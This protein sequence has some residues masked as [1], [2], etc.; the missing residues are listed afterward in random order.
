MRQMLP[1]RESVPLAATRGQGQPSAQRALPIS[2]L[3]DPPAS[4]AT[5]LPAPLSWCIGDAATI[6]P[7]LQRK[8]SV[9]NPSDPLELEADMVAENVMRAVAP[10]PLALAA[11]TPSALQRKCEDCDSEEDVEIHAKRTLVDG[12]SSVLPASL[13]VE[14]AVRSAVAGGRP[15]PDSA[16][17]FLEPRFGH[18]FSRVR[19]HTDERADAAARTVHARA[20]TR[21]HDIVFA[22]GEYAPHSSS[23]LRLLAHEL[24]HVLQQQGGRRNALSTASA[25]ESVRRNPEPLVPGRTQ[26]FDL[27]RQHAASEPRPAARQPIRVRW[28]GTL[29]G[30]LFSFIRPYA[31]SAEDAARVT[32]LVLES[33]IQFVVRGRSVSREEWERTRTS[34][35]Y[36]D[37]ALAELLSRQLGLAPAALQAQAPNGTTS[38]E[39]SVLTHGPAPAAARRGERAAKELGPIAPTHADWL[40]FE[41]NE[42]LARLYLRLME[43]YAGLRLTDVNN[44][45]A[46]GGFS[47]DELNALLAGDRHLQHFTDLIAQAF[48]EYRDAG[49]TDLEV[50][51]TLI[52]RI[53]EQFVWGNP[54]ATR[55]QLKIGVGWPEQR[56]GIVD[57]G[58]ELLLYDGLAAPLPSFAG[59]MMRDHGFIGAQQAQ[60]FGINIADIEDPGLRQL[61]NALRQQFGDPTRMVGQAARVYFQNTELVNARVQEGLSTEVKQRFLDA[62]PIFIGFLAGHGL[63][64][65]LMAS[66]NPIGAGIGLALR[67]LLTAAGYLL[68]I[69]F[70]GSAMHRLL[71]AAAHL[72]RVHRNDDG[73]LT[74]LSQHHLDEAAAP[75]RS[76][77][78]DL[79]LTVG[80]IG[81]GRLLR[82]RVAIE[83]TRCRFRRQRGR[84]QRR[85]GEGQQLG[86][87]LEQIAAIRRQIIARGQVT[88]IAGRQHA[89]ALD[90]GVPDA[91]VL[92][93]INS[94]QNIFVS[95]NGN[96][97]FYKNG[98][99]VVTPRGRPA[100]IRTAYGRGGRIPQRRLADVRDLQGTPEAR[101]G[102]AEPPV[103]LGEWLA[104]QLGDFAV[105]QIWP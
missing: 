55:N 32:N 71:S 45:A 101:A 30:S 27:Q 61:L 88:E 3:A 42:P 64:T 10:T 66:A 80:T 74:A 40:V 15:L 52:E 102:D 56:L 41:S 54:T 58:S 83:C 72:S 85:R 96:W 87:T 29:R 35:F 94:P 105:F 70:L 11:M 81:L 99:V 62:L 22:A 95:R 36:L 48:A 65:L 104:Q 12:T 78:A 18:D 82:G 25:A 51:S 89:G 86:Y 63:A 103:R 13:H 23:G 8:M 2:A 77:V 53:L 31:A 76:M 97:L 75:I 67:G 90:H 14:A 91:I 7:P 50:F 57:R 49:G 24:A 93:T 98:T 100:F 79:A 9:S 19:I 73:S 28:R 20:F 4:M 26:Q 38:D 34:S 69:E 60:E 46:A 16:R 5:E 37:T 1:A 21:G 84:E 47:V 92:R 44:G 68:Q 43:H 33:A 59:T 6:I 39:E 17:S